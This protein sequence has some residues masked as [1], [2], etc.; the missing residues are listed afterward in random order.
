[1]ERSDYGTNDVGANGGVDDVSTVGSGT[2]SGSTATTDASGSPD[3]SGITGSSTESYGDGRLATAK[4]KIG[5]AKEKVVDRM[6]ATADWIKERDIDQVKGTI[7]QQ[8]RDHPGR[9]LLIA[10]GLGYL[11]GRAFRG[12]NSA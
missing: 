9:T 5:Q 8:V 7:E 3:N 11:I 10:A 4:H 12:G 1:M 2:S 6:H